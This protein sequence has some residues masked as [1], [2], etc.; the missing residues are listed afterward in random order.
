M[1]VVDGKLQIR[2]WKDKNN[3]NRKTAEVIADSVY[4]GDSKPEGSNYSAPAPSQ[5]GYGGYSAPAAPG[6]DFAMLEDDDQ[7][8]PF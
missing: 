2:T 1:A 3:N 8:L 5:G 4:F 7:Q 6:S